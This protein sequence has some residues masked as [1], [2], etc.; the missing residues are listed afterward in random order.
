MQN[1]A[2]HNNDIIVQEVLGT[3]SE[4]CKAGT[5]PTRFRSFER[6]IFCVD[7]VVVDY[8]LR[9]SECRSFATKSGPRASVNRRRFMVS[10]SPVF[11]SD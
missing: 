2:A 6:S 3:Y 10:A 11:S 1:S 7:D 5:L 9:M 4:K 8:G